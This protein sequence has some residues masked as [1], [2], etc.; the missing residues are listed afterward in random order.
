MDAAKRK[1][2]IKQNVAKWKEVEGDLKEMGESNPSKRKSQEKQSRQPKKPKIV[3]EPVVG[4][5]AEG[6]K[7]VTPAKHGVG[8]GIMKGPS[9]T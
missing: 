7:T 1:A 8:K 9:T 6:R 5:E 4:L 3:L 2:V